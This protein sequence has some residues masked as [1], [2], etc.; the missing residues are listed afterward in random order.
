MDEVPSS[1]FEFVTNEP[2][3]ADVPPRRKLI[4]PYPQF[5]G[6]IKSEDKPSLS[7]RSHYSLYACVQATIAHFRGTGVAVVDI[8]CARR[9]VYISAHRVVV[10]E[11]ALCQLLCQPRAFV[12]L[13]D[14]RAIRGLKHF[15]RVIIVHIRGAKRLTERRGGG[16]IPV[17]VG[18]LHKEAIHM[19]IR[20][21]E[22]G[23]D[24]VGLRPLDALEVVV[25]TCTD[26]TA[27]IRLPILANEIGDRATQ[28]WCSIGCSQVSCSGG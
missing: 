16:Y 25:T 23:G 18:A 12:D 15:Q 1:I 2:Y 22:H 20:I 5:Q 17:C 24:I 7:D 6:L 26:C 14:Y 4:L 9:K 3:V 8:K 21:S 27:G 13:L 28:A 11:V 19:P 10:L